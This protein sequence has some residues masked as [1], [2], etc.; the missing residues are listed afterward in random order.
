[1]SWDQT[2]VLAAIEGVEPWFGYRRLNLKIE[3]DGSNTLVPGERFVF[4]ELKQRKLCS[5]R[6]KR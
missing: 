2:A 4:M 5:R 3:A 1:M 6:S